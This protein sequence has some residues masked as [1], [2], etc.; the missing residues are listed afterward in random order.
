MFSRGFHPVP[1]LRTCRLCSCHRP[2]WTRRAS[3]PRA[4]GSTGAGPPPR[5]T[6][7]AGPW[8]RCS[9][10]DANVCG[11][12]S[13]GTARRWENLCPADT[14]P[15]DPAVGTAAPHGPRGWA[16][17]PWLCLPWVGRVAPS[18]VV[19]NAGDLRLVCRVSFAGGRGAPGQP[20][21]DSAGQGGEEGLASSLGVQIPVHRHPS[22]QNHLQSRERGE[23]P[24]AVE[25]TPWLPCVE[26]S[27][28]PGWVP[29]SQRAPGSPSQGGAGVV[30]LAL[31]AQAGCLQKAPCILGPALQVLHNFCLSRLPGRWW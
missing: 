19:C 5:A 27:R 29:V 1:T 20:G 30:F 17:L 26:C 11:W 31:A 25:F 4:V 7:R 14:M 28:T 10:P 23:E 21:G 3:P 6:G 8:L 18:S 22:F 16:S 2:G 24:V 12:N 9:S 13:P 15:G